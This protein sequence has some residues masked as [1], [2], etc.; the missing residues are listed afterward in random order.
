[1]KIARLICSGPEVLILTEM[2]TSNIFNNLTAVE[3]PI[4]L[5]LLNFE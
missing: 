1:M 5:S 3:I 4:I 2:L